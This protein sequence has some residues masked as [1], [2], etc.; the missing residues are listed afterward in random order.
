MDNHQIG[1]IMIEQNVLTQEQVDRLLADQREA[2]KPFGELA[3]TM[4]GIDEHKVHQ[5]LADQIAYRAPQIKLCQEAFEPEVLGVITA[6]EAWDTLVLPIR[7]EDGELLCA[8]TVETLPAAIELLS[9]KL[10]LPYRFALAEM[11]PIEEFI[12][13]MYAYEGVDVADDSEA[14]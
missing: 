7:V 6:R 5:A 2:D 10:D 8:T 1:Q 4:Y 3:E 9:E 11:R 12:A 13:N 14:A